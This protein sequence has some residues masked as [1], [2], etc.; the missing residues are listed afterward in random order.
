M[1]HSSVLPLPYIVYLFVQEFLAKFNSKFNSKS[2]NIIL[3]WLLYYYTAHTHTIIHIHMEIATKVEC[4]LDHPSWICVCV[5]VCA[6]MCM[7]VYI[8]TYSYIFNNHCK[9]IK[10]L[11]V[12]Y[13]ELM[14]IMP[15][16]YVV[17]TI[18]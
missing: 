16:L 12:S 7:C 17:L 18:T 3:L 10:C 9:Q 1:G 15:S 8:H 5:R 6:C 11:Y 4:F 2:I 14:K 13:L